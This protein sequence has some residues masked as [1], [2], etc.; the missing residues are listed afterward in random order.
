MAEEEIEVVKEEM[1]MIELPEESLEVEDTADGGAMIKM[2]SITVK[3]GNEHFANIVEDVDQSVV[4][5]D[6]LHN[7]RAEKDG[8]VHKRRVSRG[9]LHLRF[10]RGTFN[11]TL[12]P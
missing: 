8:G 9:A 3:E 7:L 2:E 6:A 12:V 1:T 4:V 5:L 10:S 11:L